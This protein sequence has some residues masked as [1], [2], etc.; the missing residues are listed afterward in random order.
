MKKSILSLA[1]SLSVGLWAN[2]ITYTATSALQISSNPF[3]LP[4]VNH[5]WSSD[6]KQGM[7]TFD[8]DVTRIEF[9][10]FQECTML[11][12]I[13]IPNTITVIRMWVF[14]GCRNLTSITFEGNACQNALVGETVF[15]GVG[16]TQNPANLI[17][18]ENW[19]Y[20][21][22]PTDNQTAWHGG[23]FNSNLYSTDGATDKQAALN[24]ITE[25]M[26]EY[27]E[28]AYLQ[29][30]VAEYVTNINN[31]TNKPEV[32]SIKQAAIEKLTPIVAVYPSIFNEGD[33]AGK[34]TGKAELLGNM[35]EP[36]TSCTA[37][38]VTDGTTTV[39][40]YNATGVGY[41]KK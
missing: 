39:T 26:G 24:A 12:S 10:A 9:A 29:S 27:S 14:H 25:A 36:C 41:I 15:E 35:G 33:A 32:N 30:L 5:A 34:A 19:N 17:L 40:L 8:G 13:T 3:D 37:V 7:I 31:A 6:T 2:S 20:E 1:L 21:A 16:T 18:P 38:E 11:T 23:Y 22:A 4:V 28:S